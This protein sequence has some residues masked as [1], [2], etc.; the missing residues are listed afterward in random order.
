MA[1]RQLRISKKITVRENQSIEK[2]LQQVQTT[3]RLT[4]DEEVRLTKAIK[5]GASAEENFREVKKKVYKKLRELSHIEEDK[6]T[7]EQKKEADKLLKGLKKL[8]MKTVKIVKEAKKAQDKLVISNLRFVISV[9]KTYQNRGFG[10][11]DLINEGNIGLIKAAL[12]FDETRG[13]KFISYAVWWIRQRLL[14]F[15]QG[16][17]RTLH[18]PGSVTS[19]QQAVYKVTKELTKRLEREPTPF[20]ISTELNVPVDVVISIMESNIRLLSIDDPFKQGE[21]NTLIDVVEN[22]Q[23]TRP[24][25]NLMHNALQEELG[26]MIKKLDSR[27]Q[28]VIRGYFGLESKDGFSKTLGDIGEEIGLTRERVRQIREN[29]IKK[30]Q[31]F[32]EK[33]QGEA[34]QKA[35]NML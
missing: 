7:T 34:K 23:A 12:R 14:Q 29:A 8:E 2:Y 10:M 26:R 15:T 21:E 31:K 24:E 20:E 6:K 33:S 1:L 4:I 32:F 25:E 19:Q 9:A 5:R 28:T 17:G 13:F 11:N 3:T 18:C 22:D 35:K 30:M 27:E 16:K